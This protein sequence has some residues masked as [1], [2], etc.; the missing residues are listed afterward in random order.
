MKKN[1]YLIIMF[2]KNESVNIDNAIYMSK[3]KRDFIYIDSSSTDGTQYLL[4][5]NNIQFIN[6]TYKNWKDLRQEGYNYAE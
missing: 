4:K 2:G 5:K 6:H 3:L 1:N